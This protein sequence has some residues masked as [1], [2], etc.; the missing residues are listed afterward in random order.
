MD[1]SSLP[2]GVVEALT[3][4]RRALDARFGERLKE[5][6]LFGSYAR[7]EAWEES[8]ID[9]LVLIE[10]V[11]AGERDEVISFAWRAGDVAP[12]T[13]LVLTPLV[14]TPE[15]FDEL[16]RRERRIAHDIDREGITL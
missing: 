14:R 13:W 11:T 6:R 1:L 10:Q 4:F 7:G 15:G 8:D 12:D 5:V 3:R 16:R 2:A 9:V